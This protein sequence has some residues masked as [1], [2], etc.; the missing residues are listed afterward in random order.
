MYS[1]IIIFFEFLLSFINFLPEKWSTYIYFK[2]LKFLT[3]YNLK[4][5]LFYVSIL[6]KT[7]NYYKTLKSLNSN[8]W[9]SEDLSINFIN[10]I[11]KFYPELIH[12]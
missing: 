10:Y 8:K 6:L 2:F 7:K 12:T 11:S 5:L 9:C 1:K 3:L 4:W